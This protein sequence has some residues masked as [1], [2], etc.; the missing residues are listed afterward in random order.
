M[1]IFG[2]G[3][4]DRDYEGTNLGDV[5]YDHCLDCGCG[6]WLT[7]YVKIFQLYNLNTHRLLYVH[8]SSTKEKPMPHTLY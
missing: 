5:R 2:K 8:F 7:T 4:A 1:E 6:S 3:I